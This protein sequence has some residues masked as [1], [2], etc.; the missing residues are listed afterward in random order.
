MPFASRVPNSP[1]VA[2]PTAWTAS[3]K[4]FV[5]CAQGETVVGSRGVKDFA[6]APRIAAEELA[7]REMKEDLATPARDIPQRPLILAVDLR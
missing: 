2:N 4:R 1:L 3:N 7:D 5:T 6:S